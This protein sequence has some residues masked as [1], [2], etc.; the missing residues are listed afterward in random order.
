MFQPL[1]RGNS[2][3]LVS[4][5]SVHC[6]SGMTPIAR[7]MGPTWGPSGTDRTQMSPLLAPWTL[8]SGNLLSGP[9]KTAH[10][11]VITRHLD[12]LRE[13]SV[14]HIFY[15]ALILHSIVL[16]T[17]LYWKGISQEPTEYS[18][19]L[20]NGDTHTINDIR[21]WLLSLIS[22]NSANVFPTNI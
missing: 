8:P 21:M 6:G 18:S 10:R 1:S 22:I 3:E 7:F 15:F 9:H 19:T 12:I 14:S 5:T 17:L 2:D 20:M 13:L 16:N 4:D 11:L